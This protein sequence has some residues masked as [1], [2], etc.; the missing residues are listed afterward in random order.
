MD[1][2]DYDTSAATRP[3]DIVSRHDLSVE[4]LDFDAIPVIDIGA[5]LGDDSEELRAAAREIYDASVNVGFLYLTNHG[6]AESVIADALA[7]I[8]L[9]FDL[10]EETKLKYNINDIKRHRGYVP[11]GALS[12]DPT[13]V[14]Q[15]QGYE[16]GLELP[17]DDPDYLAGSAL[18]G[19]NVWP[20]EL[21]GFQRAVYRYYAEV[22]ALGH[23]IFRLYALGLGL[24]E[25][26]FESV[27]TK[28][29][30]QLRLIYYPTTDPM[31]KPEDAV[32][33]G[34]HTDYES[35]TI[36]YQT[37]A[38]LE[39]QNRGGQWVEA[40]PIPGSFIVNIGDMLQR[41]TNDLFVSTPHRVINRSGRK[42]YS[43][44]F[45]LGT[46]H[47]CI[48]QCLD[49]CVDADHPPAYP[50]THFGYWVENMHSYAYAYRWAE[51][52]KLPDPEAAAA[53]ALAK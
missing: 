28:P 5:T 24:E 36:L 1:L 33:I 52:G 46:D 30:A 12:A 8:E 14:D 29:M 16:V 9:F 53:K 32:G 49:N 22:L 48:V 25:D 26:H 34:P 50:P 43:L 37:E 27:L 4:R 38:G 11:I 17:D 42:R 2:P 45:F 20:E 44:P 21:P 18:F 10:P 23:R 7:Q 31:T 47:D 40:P 13:I 35:F 51:R 41:W 39:V 6:I 15:Q 3:R 19:P